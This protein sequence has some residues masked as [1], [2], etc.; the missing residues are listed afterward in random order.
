MLISSL[1]GLM[2]G[3]PNLS[4]SVCAYARPSFNCAQENGKNKDVE[5]TFS[6]KLILFSLCVLFI[7]LE[8]AGDQ[9]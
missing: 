8:G 7:L 2:Q 1:D 6:K 5:M 4:Q 3:F 9:R